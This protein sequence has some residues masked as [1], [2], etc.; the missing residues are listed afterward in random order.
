M[1]KKHSN[2]RDFEHIAEEKKREEGCGRVW[3]GR[4]WMGKV[5]KGREGCGREGRGVEGKGREEEREK[6]LHHF[7]TLV[8]L[9]FAHTEVG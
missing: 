6:T 7:G 9:L 2:S 1:E 3:N 5:W 4:V 8:L